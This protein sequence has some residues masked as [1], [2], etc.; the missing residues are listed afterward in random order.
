MSEP[1][2]V[3]GK[4]PQLIGVL[5]FQ[6]ALSYFLIGLRLYTRAFIKGAIGVD[7]WCLISTA[8]STDLIPSVKRHDDLPTSEFAKAMLYILTGQVFIALATGMGKVSVAMFLLRIVMKPWHRWF[9]WFCNISITIFSIFLAIAVFAQCTPTESIWNPLLADQRV[10]NL[11]LT[12]VAISYCSYA[13]TMD[14]VLAAFPWI[15]LHGLNMKAKD[16]RTICI[17]LSLGVFAGICGIFRTSGL[18]SLSNAQDY[19]CKFS[20]L[21]IKDD[22]S[23]KEIDSISDSVMWTVSEVTATIVCLTLPSLRPL[24][25]KMRGEDFSS[26]G[27]QQHDDSAYRHNPSFPLGSLR[28]NNDKDD[29]STKIESGVLTGKND[30]DEAILL[31]GSTKGNI[32]RTQEVCMTY[33]ERRG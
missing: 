27:Y 29:T 7:D 28:E 10:C 19:L 16:R 21:R 22:S 33:G 8:V 20:Q 15:A 5:W 23:N 24:Y 32:I 31:N 13:A 17:S 4:G 6:M 2:G 25:K 30:S 18:T 11:S 1:A 26:G 14:F 9:L 3:G 12:V